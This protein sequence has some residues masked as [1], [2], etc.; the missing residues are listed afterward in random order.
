MLKFRANERLKEIALAR[1]DFRPYS[2]MHERL[3]WGLSIQQ[4]RVRFNM[5]CPGTIMTAL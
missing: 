4:R 2:E 1:K 3:N 5:Y